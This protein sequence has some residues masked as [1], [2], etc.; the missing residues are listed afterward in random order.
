MIDMNIDGHRYRVNRS[1]RD[2]LVRHLR[3]IRTWLRHYWSQRRMFQKENRSRVA[4]MTV[5]V[6]EYSQR[7]RELRRGLVDMD[8]ALADKA[9]ES[10]AAS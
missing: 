8:K 2:L 9:A 10:R 6:W 5:E 4:E 1:G 7:L 3:S